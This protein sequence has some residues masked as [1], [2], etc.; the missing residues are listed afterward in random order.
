MIAE[1]GFNC[2][3]N[4]DISARIQYI[5]NSLEELKLQEERKNYFE[6]VDRLRV[7]GQTT[8]HLHDPSAVNPR[9]KRNGP[10]SVV[11]ANISTLFTNKNPCASLPDRLVGY[12]LGWPQQAIDDHQ[13]ED[14]ETKIGYKSDADVQE[15]EKPRCLFGCGT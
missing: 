14:D 6:E 13:D 5:L 7:L 15:T 10:S 4:V 3:E 9:R 11:T 2:R 12:L 1:Q 8:E